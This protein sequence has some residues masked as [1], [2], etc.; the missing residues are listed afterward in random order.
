MGCRQNSFQPVEFEALKSEPD[1]IRLPFNWSWLW[2]RIHSSANRILFA[3]IVLG[4][5]L[6]V[7]HKFTF[8]NVAVAVTTFT[9]FALVYWPEQTATP[10]G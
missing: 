8:F 9:T 6:L 4:A 10:E 5:T 2:Q 7:A 3:L 1:Q